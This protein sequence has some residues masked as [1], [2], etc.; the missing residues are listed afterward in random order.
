VIEI[1]LLRLV[2]LQLPNVSSVQVKNMSMSAVGWLTEFTR[3]H[4]SPRRT[5]MSVQNTNGAMS[6][7]QWHWMK[8]DGRGFS[9]ISDRG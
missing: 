5:N 9:Y 3:W 7:S 8:L 4:K 6:L 1:S 2:I